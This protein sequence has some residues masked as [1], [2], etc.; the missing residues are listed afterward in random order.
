MRINVMVAKNFK[1]FLDYDNFETETRADR[2]L[3]FD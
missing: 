1:R 3:K 2:P